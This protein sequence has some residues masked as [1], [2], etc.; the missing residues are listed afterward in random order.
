M[1]RVGQLDFLTMFS[2]TSNCPRCG[3]PDL[4]ELSQRDGVDPL[5]KAPWSRLQGLFGAPLRYCVWCRLQFYD[6]RPL[7]KLKHP[8][9]SKAVE[10]G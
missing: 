4:Q 6:M 3:N 5:Y 9:F 10:Q 1:Y 2:T 8:R 7:R